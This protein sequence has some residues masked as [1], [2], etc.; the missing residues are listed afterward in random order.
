MLVCTY[1]SRSFLFVGDAEHVEEADLVRLGPARLH[2]DV[3]KV[4]HHGSRTSSS[5]AFLAVVAP[6]E[7][8]ISCGAR[9][10]FGHPAPTTLDSLAAAGVRTWRT[11]HDGAVTISTD[12]ASL[13]ITTAAH[14]DS[15][16]SFDPSPAPPVDGRGASF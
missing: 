12:G 9:N 4:G 2:A 1:G 11:D 13:E 5:P 15:L 7:A 14:A 10:R 8:V 16:W 3:L 6:R